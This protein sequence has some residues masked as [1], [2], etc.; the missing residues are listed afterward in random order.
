M[1]RPAA[2]G[3]LLSVGA[4][5]PVGS[6]RATPTA[7]EHAPAATAWDSPLTHAS[8]TK[9][10]STAGGTPPELQALQQL[11]PDS[12]A[13][14]DKATGLRYEALKEV[15]YTLGV[16]TGVRWRYEAI[17][18]LLEANRS[19]L[20]RVFDFRPLMLH[21]GR[22]APA[23]VDRTEGAYR[24]VSATE[25]RQTEATYTIEEEAR[26]VTRPPD[27]RDYL[28]QSYPTFTRPD[29]A[30]L[31]RDAAER[32]IWAAAV[33]NGWQEGVAQADR[34][35]DAHLAR[36]RRGY[37]GMT[38]CKLLALQGVVDIPLLAEN[39]LG[40]TVN[41]RMLSVGERLFRIPSGTGFEPV[42][43]WKPILTYI[44]AT[45]GAVSGTNPLPD[46]GRDSSQE[47]G[48]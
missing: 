11:A 5:L 13:P 12:G 31:P 29:P 9:R 26:L 16:Q 33:S 20:D 2:I 4:L 38:R 8:H 24:I 39:R 48:S 18:K 32:R 45:P 25:A 10:P 42:G 23:V 47:G 43:N 19:T 14:A 37:L 3:L 40:V 30:M 17:D 35:F 46:R 7:Q 15:A 28:V 22:V 34:L 1:K 41:G 36:L 6:P 44:P 27:W 21:D